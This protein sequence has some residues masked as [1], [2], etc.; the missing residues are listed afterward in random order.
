MLPEERKFAVDTNVFI[1]AYRDP[2]FNAAL[3]RFH[4]AF[5]PFEYLSAVVAQELRAGMQSAQHRARL[6]RVVLEVYSRRGRVLTPSRQA[7]SESGNVLAEMA[8]REGLEVGKVSKAF[9]NDVLLALSCREAGVV[10]VTDNVRD[11]G[12]IQRYVQFEYTAPWPEATAE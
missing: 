6:E 3:N 8:W 11:F 7:W 10:L 2:G 1:R 5:A 12:R 4:S 9:G